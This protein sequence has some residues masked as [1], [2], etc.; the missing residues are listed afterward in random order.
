MSLCKLCINIFVPPQE[1]KK[2]ED[3][4][5]S[6][7]PTWRKKPR[8]CG[9][10][11]RNSAAPIG[12]ANHLTIESLRESAKAG[13]YICSRILPE[14]EGKDPLDIPPKVALTSNTLSNPR[15]DDNG[16]DRYLSFWN[17]TPQGN[18]DQTLASFV[19]HPV[20]V[21]NPFLD[22]QASVNTGSDECFQLAARWMQEC[23]TTHESCCKGAN[24]SWYPARLLDSGDGI[25]LDRVRLMKPELEHPLGPYATVLHHPHCD[26]QIKLLKR[27]HDDFLHSI[28]L[29]NL[30]K[31]WSDAMTIAKRLGIRYIWIDALCV[32][33]DCEEEQQQN[34]FQE[35]EI[36][37]KSWVTI[38]AAGSI[39]D[40][41]GC[42]FD[43][44]SRTIERVHVDLPAAHGADGLQKFTLG[45]RVEWYFWEKLFEQPLLEKAESFQKRLFARRVL[46]MGRDQLFWECE[47]ADCCELFP[48]SIPRH[49]E[50]HNNFA[51]K[52]SYARYRQGNATESLAHLTGDGVTEAAKQQVN[53][54]IWESIT[55]SYSQ[56]TPTVP[57]AK[58]PALSNIAREMSQVF[59]GD[60]YLAGTWKSQL[61]RALLWQTTGK[62]GT[63]RSQRY[64]AP[65]WSWASV[66]GEIQWQGVPLPSYP[67]TIDYALVSPIDDPLGRVDGGVLRITSNF[68][69]VNWRRCERCTGYTSHKDM[70]IPDDGYG[71]SHRDFSLD[72]PIHHS[73]FNVNLDDPSEALTG[74]L[75]VLLVAWSYG[76][77]FDPVSQM[78]DRRSGPYLLFLTRV[79]GTTN[80]FR[81]VAVGWNC[82]YFPTEWI[83]SLPRETI[84]LV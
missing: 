62:Q 48:S 24:E 36:Y 1:P 31:T 3:P 44:D 67:A 41:E 34:S 43:R 20:S 75:F 47:K 23:E 8:L 73:A 2:P 40:D 66:D 32:L 81:R 80:F 46:H 29:S 4:K 42:F 19:L 57:E 26:S 63:H 14:L 70:S 83:E 16:K 10:G 84:F 33:Q 51:T 56:C 7:N 61:P 50:L 71:F 79:Q 38:S 30:P 60:E 49:L 12:S 54:V 69:L 15:Q 72:E 25:G 59:K 55:K 39:N 28:P 74:D 18:E 53:A 64:R 68:G 27:N 45:R 22:Y 9:M 35:S 37:R 13:C 5:P 78:P 77:F 6:R 17:S 52:R 76:T 21:S 65:S 82:D 58:L 11:K